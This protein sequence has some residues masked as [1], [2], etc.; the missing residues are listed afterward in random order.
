M[1]TIVLMILLQMLIPV[2]SRPQIFFPKATVEENDEM[3]RKSFY[4]KFE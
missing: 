1:T 4:K 2:F 3:V